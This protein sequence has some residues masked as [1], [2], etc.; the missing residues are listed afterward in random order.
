MRGKICLKCDRIL[1]VRSL[2]GRIAVARRLGARAATPSR[3]ISTTTPSYDLHDHPSRMIL[4]TTLP[5]DL[6]DHPS[7]DSRKIPQDAE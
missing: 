3:M 2:G 6:Y 5:Y 1:P 4:T 7:P